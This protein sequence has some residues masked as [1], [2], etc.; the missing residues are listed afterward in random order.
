MYT[1]QYEGFH[2]GQSSGALLKDVAVFQRCSSIEVSGHVYLCMCIITCNGIG[3]CMYVFPSVAEF[4][5]YNHE[6]VV[7]L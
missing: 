4:V 7:S 2:M 5:G 1:C 3:N 6:C